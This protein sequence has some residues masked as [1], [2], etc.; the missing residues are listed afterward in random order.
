[1]MSFTEQETDNLIDETGP[2]TGDDDCL[3]QYVELSDEGESIRE[4]KKESVIRAFQP[5]DSDKMTSLQV[6]A[7]LQDRVENKDSNISNDQHEK[8]IQ[9]LLTEVRRAVVTHQA[10]RYELEASNVSPDV[11]NIVC[12]SLSDEE[13]QNFLKRFEGEPSR[14]DGLLLQL[15]AFNLHSFTFSKKAIKKYKYQPELKNYFNDDEHAT[16]MLQALRAGANWQDLKYVYLD[17][18]HRFYKLLKRDEFK[19][20]YHIDISLMI[21]E[22]HFS[23]A[24]RMAANRKLEEKSPNYYGTLFF[25]ID[26]CSETKRNEILSILPLGTA[27]R[28]LEQKKP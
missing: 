12:K 24:A 23:Y 25:S 9:T 17:C 10:T 6:I 3:D 19:K 11:M 20:E 28:Y 22:P 13:K 15:L 2:T 18:E 21:I 16:L 27:S 1:M 14:K 4:R 26:K 8:R 7:S 5:I